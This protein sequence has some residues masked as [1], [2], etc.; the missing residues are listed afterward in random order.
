VRVEDVGYPEWRGEQDR[1]AERAPDD[2]QRAVSLLQRARKV[3]GNSVRDQ[4]RD[5]QQDAP[6]LM[7]RPA[8]VRD[9]RHRDQDRTEKPD[10]QPDPDHPRGHAAGQDARNRRSKERGRP[11]QHAGERRRHVL[12]S[13]R[14]HAERECQP[15]DAERRR[16][17][18][19][20]SRQRP[21]SRG[22]Q[23]ERDKPDEDA[24]KRHAVRVERLEPLR[25]QQ[26]RRPPDDAGQDQQQRINHTAR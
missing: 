13:E 5:D 9:A 3:H 7:A 22:N 8:A 24:D 15:Q 10:R 19:I 6:R 17:R 2:R 18:A 1:D 4:G 14:K 26:E 11:V 21:A 12:F 25:D 20:G 16:R 23:G